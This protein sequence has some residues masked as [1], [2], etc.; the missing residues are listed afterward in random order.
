MPV[1]TPHARTHT[2]E[3][4]GS[5]WT[6]VPLAPPPPHEHLA[7]L[8]ACFPATLP[9]LP[10][11]VA[12]LELVQLAGGHVAPPADDLSVTDGGEQPHAGSGGQGEGAGGG[13]GQGGGG[14]GACGACS[15]W[16]AAAV[17]ALRGAGVRPGE[18]ALALGRHFSLRDLLKWAA[19]MQGLHGPALEGRGLAPLAAAARAMCG[20]DGGAP[21]GVG[22]SGAAAAAA[23]VRYDLS[24]VDQRLREAAFT[25]CG[26]V[27]AALVAGAGARR[28]L[29]AALA[30]L[31]GLPAE[32]A[33]ER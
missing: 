11:A 2:Q 29:L 27:L 25:E 23:P 33:V 28:R 4:L 1:H 26:D 17:T 14:G 19:R 7:M 5:L 20:A 9:L 32:Q 16:A 31:W 24:L 21:H 15:W 18:L 22:A 12:A 10:G 30:G 13:G 3:L 8:A 6:Y